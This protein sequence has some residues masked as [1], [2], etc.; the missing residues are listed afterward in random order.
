MDFLLL[1][2]PFKLLMDP[3]KQEEGRYDDGS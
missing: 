3:Q 1:L 2:F